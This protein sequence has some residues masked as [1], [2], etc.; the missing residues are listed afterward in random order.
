MRLI[1]VDELEK[2]LFPG[3]TSGGFW[4]FGQLCEILDRQ[5]TIDAVRHGKWVEVVVAETDTSRLIHWL[6]SECKIV[7]DHNT[8]K[9]CPKCGAKMDGE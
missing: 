1:D 2:D 8:D 4:G 6:C 9:Y 3:G 7:V 5:P